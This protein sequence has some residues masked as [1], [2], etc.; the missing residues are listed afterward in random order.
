MDGGS[1]SRPWVDISNG[2]I[3]F[4]FTLLSWVKEA[5]AIL[6]CYYFY[7][8]SSLWYSHLRLAYFI[9]TEVDLVALQALL[10]E[11]VLVSVVLSLPQ[12]WL[13]GVWNQDQPARST[14]DAGI[15]II[16]L[17][18]KIW[19]YWVYIYIRWTLIRPSRTFTDSFTVWS[20]LLCGL[21]QCWKVK[22]GSRVSSKI[23]QYCAPYIFHSSLTSAPVTATKK[24]PHKRI[25][26][27]PCFTVGMGLF[28]W[29]SVLAVCQT[30][31]LVLRPYSLILVS[32][33]QNSIFHLVSESSRCKP[34]R[35]TFFFL[36]ID[37]TVLL[38]IDKAI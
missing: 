3:S 18:L 30:L 5:K 29:R 35:D 11:W 28:G 9:L 13:S 6:V 15:L 10:G 1:S 4:C 22:N 17:R 27:P 26:P 37:L 24:H 8:C 14:K 19:I 34:S 2:N 31:C 25:F 20:I 38:G 7:T 32:S 36:W 16:I 12:Y 33:D 21:G 23:W